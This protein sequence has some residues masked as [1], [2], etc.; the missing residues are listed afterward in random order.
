MPSPRHG[1]GALP[2]GT[3][4]IGTL[5]VRALASELERLADDG[6][7]ELDSHKRA[8]LVGACEAFLAAQPVT[9][10]PTTHPT[11]RQPLALKPFIAALYGGAS[12]CTTG[13]EP[14]LAQ[15]VRCTSG[16]AGTLNIR[17]SDGVL[18][19][20]AK[21]VPCHTD[22]SVR[23]A[24][25]GIT[26]ARVVIR[27]GAVHPPPT[28]SFEHDAPVKSHPRIQ[29]MVTA[30]EDCRQDYADVGTIVG[31]PTGVV[32][33]HYSALGG[34]RAGACPASASSCHWLVCLLLW[35]P[36]WCLPGQCQLPA[37]GLRA[38]F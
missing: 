15:V 35:P 33:S 29:L 6:R 5:S 20:W 23:A 28:W 19:A 3:F 9:G 22:G 11:A 30:Y 18:L 8:L 37:T 27:R 24:I 7:G 10:Q 36:C 25:D 31:Q 12:M 21:A 38:C 2:G 17:F 32:V 34:I 1:G 14:V 26:A 16:P 4:R 13:P